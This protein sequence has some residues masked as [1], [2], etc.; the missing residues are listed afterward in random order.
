[1][2]NKFDIFADLIVRYGNS[3]L[4][5]DRLE[6]KGLGVTYLSRFYGTRKNSMEHVDI[7][8]RMS[9]SDI[10]VNTSS[11]NVGTSVQKVCR[12]VLR[13]LMEE[14]DITGHAGIF[15]TY[16]MINY[17][18]SKVVQYAS[19]EDEADLRINK[20]VNGA[21]HAYVNSV[22]AEDRLTTMLLKTRL[23]NLMKDISGS[24]TLDQIDWMLNI[25][26]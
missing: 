19:V 4:N 21:S 6:S 20:F 18:S 25:G 26:E 11:R 12:S 23:E 2:T 5:V 17:T 1:M 16:Y 3:G 24:K 13:T 10:S 14:L 7:S 15:V 8:S 22:V 9:V